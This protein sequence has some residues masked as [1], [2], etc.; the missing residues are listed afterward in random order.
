MTSVY[1]EALAGVSFLVS[2]GLRDEWQARAKC[3]LSV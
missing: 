2:V 1:T 3:W